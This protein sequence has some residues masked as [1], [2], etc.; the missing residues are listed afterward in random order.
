MGRL[1]KPSQQNRRAGTIWKGMGMQAQNRP[2]ARP[3]ERAGWVKEKRSVWVTRCSQPLFF[4][5][6][7]VLLFGDEEPAD[8]FAKK[9]VHGYL[10]CGGRKAATI[11]GSVSMRGAPMRSRQ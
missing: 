6:G 8:E 10:A 1:A 3:R 4:Y 5:F 9:G 2:M 7:N 11:L